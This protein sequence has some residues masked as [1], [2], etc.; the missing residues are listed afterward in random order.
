M[1]PIGKLSEEPQEA[2]NKDFRNIRQNH[3]RK[4]S[5]VAANEDLLKNLFTSSDPVISSK[6]KK[7]HEDKQIALRW[8]HDQKTRRP[9]TKSSIQSQT[10]WKEK[11]RKIE[12]QVGGWGEQR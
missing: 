11:S 1:V 12:I 2:R 9:I 7:C 3:P 4:F 5:R 6:R 8:S 10:H